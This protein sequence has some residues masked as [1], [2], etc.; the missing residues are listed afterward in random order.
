MI[1][2]VTTIGDDTTVLISIYVFPLD[3]ALSVHNKIS[4]FCVL[5]PVQMEGWCEEMGS[6]STLRLIHRDRTV[7]LEQI[8]TSRL[9]EED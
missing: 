4:T 1:F 6:T 7:S 5:L 8:D 3:L 2:K 9:D